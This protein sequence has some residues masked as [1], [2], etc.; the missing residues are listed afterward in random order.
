MLVSR[1]LLT[2]AAGHRVNVTTANS[3]FDPEDA[4]AKGRG[5]KQGL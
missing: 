2:A 5:A 1:G 3:G 4:V